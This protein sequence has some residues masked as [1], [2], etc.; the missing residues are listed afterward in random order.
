MGEKV[1]KVIVD[2]YALMSK[3]SGEITAKANEYL[4]NVRIGKVEG[5]IHPIIVYEFLLQVVR[6]RIPI[7]T[8]AEEA[9]DFLESYFSTIK[10]ENRLAM[11][12]AKVRVKSEKQLKQRRLSICDAFTIALA[13]IF[14]CKALFVKPEKELEKEIKKK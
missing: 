3:A 2:T 5:L 10:V 11:E 4:N 14:R 12:A 7:F 1:R 6:R 8:S 13:K 9:L